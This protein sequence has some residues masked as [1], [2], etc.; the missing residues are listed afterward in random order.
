ML[1]LGRHDLDLNL[2][3][4]LCLC[5]SV[6]VCL[7]QTPF[8]LPLPLPFP[9]CLSVRL[10]LSPLPPFLLLHPP[11]HP[12]PQRLL[13]VKTNEWRNI[14]E[15]QQRLRRVAGQ[16]QKTQKESQCLTPTRVTSSGLSW[17]RLV[18][19]RTCHHAHPGVDGFRSVSSS[20][21]LMSYWNIISYLEL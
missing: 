12:P 11:A 9:L 16:T 7:S 20:S 13:S 4:S 21:H 6:S 19:Q 15:G 1:N 18:D 10:S 14:G 2:S 8:P 17:S 3:R 5:D